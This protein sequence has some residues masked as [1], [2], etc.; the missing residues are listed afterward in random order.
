ME[1]VEYSFDFDALAEVFARIA[2]AAKAAGIHALEPVM[3]R[4]PEQG[5]LGNV[6]REMVERGDRMSAPGTN[7]TT[8]TVPSPRA[9]R[10]HPAPSNP[11]GGSCTRT[12]PLPS[13][14]SSETQPTRW[15]SLNY[16]GLLF[17]E[18]G[19]SVLPLTVCDRAL[20]SLPF[21]QPHTPP[22]TTMA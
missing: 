17:S 1:E 6:I 14:Y 13:I 22:N 10:S 11:N 5:E 4:P 18:E 12:L 16:S 19:E 3:G 7:S 20:F 2:C 9:G 8:P 21:R 15:N